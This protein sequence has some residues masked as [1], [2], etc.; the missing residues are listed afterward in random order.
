MRTLT[1][2]AVLMAGAL[3]A[4]ATAAPAQAAPRPRIDL[5]GADV[6]SY[7]LDDA[8]SRPP[9]RTVTGAPFDGAY[10]AVARGRRR[11]PARSRRLRA[12]DGNPGRDRPAGD[13]R[14]P[15]PPPARCAAPGRTRRT[16]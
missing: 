10:A 16:S 4:A 3:L 2:A 15:S 8:G 6:G 7:M 12:R 5:R 14:W 9:G 1:D 13:A 11:H